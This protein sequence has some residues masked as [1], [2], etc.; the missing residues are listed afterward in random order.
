MQESITN[1][2]Q[3]F[4]EWLDANEQWLNEYSAETGA[5]RELDFNEEAF[6]ENLYDKYLE[7][8]NK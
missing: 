5:D 3:D 7:H 4:S 8:A 1:K 2:I 6:A